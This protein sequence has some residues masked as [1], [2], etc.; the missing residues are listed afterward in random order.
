MNVLVKKCK[1]VLRS[2]LVLTMVFLVGTT[3]LMQAYATYAQIK[4]EH[5]WADNDDSAGKRPDGIEHTVI[6][7]NTGN[8]KQETVMT[9]KL[10]T[11]E[12][13]KKPDAESNDSSTPAGENDSSVPAGE[14]DSSASTGE[15]NSFTSV[16]QDS[17]ST[18]AGEDS[19][20]VS[21]GGNDSSVF[22]GENNSSTSVGENSVSTPAEEDS[23]AT[24]ASESSTPAPAG[25]NTLST[26]AAPVISEISGTNEVAQRTAEAMGLSEESSQEISNQLDGALKNAIKELAGNE[27]AINEGAFETVLDKLKDNTNSTQSWESS[28]SETDAALSIRDTPLAGTEIMERT[29]A[30]FQGDHYGISP[31]Y[32]DYALDQD[33]NR[34]K[35]DPELHGDANYTGAGDLLAPMN[36]SAML[37]DTSKQALKDADYTTKLKITIQVVSGHNSGRPSSSISGGTGSKYEK[38]DWTE[39]SDNLKTFVSYDGKTWIGEN[40]EDTYNPERDFVLYTTYTYLH[41]RPASYDI[42]P[43][44]PD[45]KPEDPKPEDPKPEDPKPEDPKPES[46]PTPTPRPTPTPEENIPEEDVP[47]S[48]LPEPETE[49]PEEEVPLSELPEP[50]VEIPEEDVPLS[51]IPKTGDSSA[52]WMGAALLSGAALL[53]LTRKRED[54]EPE[55]A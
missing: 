2:A 13:A 8:G 49:I 7:D 28:N 24:P 39:D 50:E 27:S 25:E 18:P 33:G 12:G 40:P 5:V 34:I 47:L 23:A 16:G 31:G 48:E 52:L 30:I 10:E 41:I 20:A 37:S 9:E 4:V 38:A 15:N 32:A 29:G 46:K 1:K 43:K 26:P 44:D 55:E 11:P 42:D 14:S 45:P 36:Y 21:I 53:V 35:Y 22:A 51:D 3:T 17:I 19:A 6:R 54:A